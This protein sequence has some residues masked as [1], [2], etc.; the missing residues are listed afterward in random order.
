MLWRTLLILGALLAIVVAD[1]ADS[2]EECEKA[3]ARESAASRLRVDARWCGE[4]ETHARIMFGY[5]LGSAMHLIHDNVTQGLTGLFM[6][7]SDVTIEAG[8]AQNRMLGGGPLNQ[9]QP[10]VFTRQNNALS[11]FYGVRDEAFHVFVQCSVETPGYTGWRV[12]LEGR[13]SEAD[14][15]CTKV[16]DIRCADMH[17]RFESL[18]ADMFLREV[19]L[20]MALSGDYDDAKETQHDDVDPCEKEWEA[21]VAC[22]QDENG[23]CRELREA[24]ETCDDTHDYSD[25]DDEDD[26]DADDDTSADEYDYEGIVAL[27]SI[28]DDALRKARRPPI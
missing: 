8:S 22:M 9:G 18:W 28:P 12:E 5:E 25:D 13:A 7:M 23:S 17:S 21:V 11:L 15:E 10:S 14:V 16:P 27:W 6:N 20:A 26:D 2:D 19:E 3:E 1:N 24:A 4:N